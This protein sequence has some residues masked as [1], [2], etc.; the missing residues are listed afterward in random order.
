MAWR[1]KNK[2]RAINSILLDDEQIS[3]DPLEINKSFKLY[4]ERLYNS[5]C[6]Y[7]VVDQNNFLDELEFPQL[8][9]EV[10]LD[11]EKI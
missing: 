4:Y 5:E 9:E 3:K 10:K 7:T 1:I 6:L 8:A 2:Q 11:L